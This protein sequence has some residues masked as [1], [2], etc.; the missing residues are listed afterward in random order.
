VA[1]VNGLQLATLNVRHFP[2]FTDLAPP[3]SLS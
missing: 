1:D 2:V 3:F